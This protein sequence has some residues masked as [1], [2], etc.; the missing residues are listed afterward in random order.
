M[1]HFLNEKIGK[2]A[3]IWMEIFE[4]KTHRFLDKKV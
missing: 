1:H 4:E 3:F 2:K